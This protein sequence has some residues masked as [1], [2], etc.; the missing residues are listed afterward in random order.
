VGIKRT[1]IIDIDNGA[2]LPPV[3]PTGNLTPV[4]VQFEMPEHPEGDWHLRAITALEGVEVPAASFT[5]HSDLE[6]LLIDAEFAN[7]YEMPLEI[8]AY[9]VDVVETDD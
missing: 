5:L 3:A 8:T 4:A 7:P 2:T 6:P 1:Q 9:A